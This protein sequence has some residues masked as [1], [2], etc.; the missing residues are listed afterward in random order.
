MFDIQQEGSA[1]KVITLR[2]A[3]MVSNKLDTPIEIKMDSPIIPGILL[4]TLKNKNRI[5]S[6]IKYAFK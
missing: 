1:R 5:L 2:S 4:E 3:L 6:Y